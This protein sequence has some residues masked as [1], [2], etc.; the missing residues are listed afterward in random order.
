MS[1]LFRTQP[2]DGDVLPPCAE[3]R[4]IEV[5]YTPEQVA[6]ALNVSTDMLRNWRE[7]RCGPAFVEISPRQVR[8]PASAIR[9]FLAERHTE[10]A[11][12]D[13]HQEGLL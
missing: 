9:A 12:I 4:P 10:S 13:I 3:T 8:Y 1:Q 2:S 7:K 6:L 5:H 11:T